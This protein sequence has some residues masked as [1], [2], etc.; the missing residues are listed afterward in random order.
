[1]AGGARRSHAGS[2]FSPRCVL[3]S[4]VPADRHQERRSL[5]RLQLKNAPGS[6]TLLKDRSL[7]SPA[8]V[9]KRR[10][11]KWNSRG[12]LTGR[13]NELI[14]CENS[15]P[16]K[17]ITPNN[18][19]SSGARSSVPECRDGRGSCRS[20]RVSELESAAVG[21]AALSAGRCSAWVVCPVYM[22][23]ASSCSR[24][25]CSRAIPWRS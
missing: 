24:F 14:S 15:S 21:N 1:M 9:R 18:S 17:G 25:A 23:D 13:F 3:R 12:L 6:K 10:P 16:A 11:N 2:K 4:I 5:Q 8:G 22:Q 19:F 7:T 20:P